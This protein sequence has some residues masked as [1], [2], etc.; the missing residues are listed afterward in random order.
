MRLAKFIAPAVWYISMHDEHGQTA[1][2]MVGQTTMQTAS[3]KASQK[4]SQ[5]TGQTASQMVKWWAACIQVEHAAIEPLIA[6]SNNHESTA[7]PRVRS[8]ILKPE[9]GFVADCN[10]IEGIHR[11]SLEKNSGLE[12]SDWGLVTWIARRFL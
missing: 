8:L 1:S 2:Q 12:L 9:R 6:G 10:F 7:D 3:Q 11:G 4:A 5:T